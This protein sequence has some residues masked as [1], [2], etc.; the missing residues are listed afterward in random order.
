MCSRV[1]RRKP[2]QRRN[3][4]RSAPSRYPE[5]TGGRAQNGCCGR[6]DEDRATKRRD[7]QDRARRV[8]TQDE[9]HESRLRPT[10]AV[11][12]DNSTMKRMP[13]ERPQMAPGGVDTA[14]L[15]RDVDRLT[16]GDPTDKRRVVVRIPQIGVTASKRV[17][18]V[19]QESTRRE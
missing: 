8:E 17:D 2:R 19:E 14:E 9:Q 3:P 18:R 7:G 16:L 11:E 10:V 13:D 15:W 5:R 6:H 12:E 1:H 4:E